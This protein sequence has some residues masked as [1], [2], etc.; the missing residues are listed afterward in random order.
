[1]RRGWSL[2]ELLVVLAL[3]AVLVGGASLMFSDLE[4]RSRRD[5]AEVEL[6]RITDEIQRSMLTRAPGPP[7][8]SLDEFPRLE[9]RLVD[10]WG[11][12]YLLRS[13]PPR[14]VSPGPDRELD[15]PDD[16]A[17]EIPQ[18]AMPVVVV[19][20]PQT[21]MEAPPPA[22]PCP[23]RRPPDRI[24]VVKFETDKMWDDGEVVGAMVRQVFL[25]LPPEALS[26][27]RRLDV[28]DV[29]VVACHSEARVHWEKDGVNHGPL[30]SWVGRGGTLI[31]TDYAG[32][33]LEKA[34][35]ECIALVPVKDTPSP[36]RAR[37][38]DLRL[39]GV[40]PDPVELQSLT[41][42]LVDRHAGT[43]LLTGVIPI[44]GQRPLA[45][46]IPVGCGRV[47]YSSVHLSKQA[48]DVAR[49]LIRRIVD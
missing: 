47:A 22:S 17:R 4:Q 15:T 16:V 46:L 7:P 31:V 24:G 35:P 45:I 2:I 36:L 26:D 8:R 20:R 29:I 42:V 32:V 39:Q 1:M 3:I 30:R 44:L 40:L 10:P 37:V 13:D 41:G 28:F 19:P 11:S 6:G 48:P 43:N 23:E 14:V 38:V 9:R 21:R 27:A 49:A 25:M 34:F 12:P 18:R 33:L 5:R